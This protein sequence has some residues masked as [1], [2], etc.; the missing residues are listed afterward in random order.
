MFFRQKLNQYGGEGIILI[1][2]KVLIKTKERSYILRESE[3]LYCR[4]SGAYSVIYIKDRQEIITSMNLQKLYMKMGIFSSIFRAGKSYLVNI[5]YVHSVNHITKELELE[6]D[7]IIPYSI[8][9][10]NIEEAFINN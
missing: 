5:S 8:L 4:A 9:F 10:R 2:K 3:I 1:M 6:G 7:I